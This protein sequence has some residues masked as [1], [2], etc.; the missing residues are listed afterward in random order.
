MDDTQHEQA[1]ERVNSNLNMSSEM[2]KLGG[3]GTY[4]ELENNPRT[5]LPTV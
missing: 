1:H 3:N 4:L 2:E 5:V